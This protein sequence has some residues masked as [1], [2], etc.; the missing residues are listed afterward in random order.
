MGG[1]AL[2][3]PERAWMARADWPRLT[4][5]GITTTVRFSASFFRWA[6]LRTTGKTAYRFAPLYKTKQRP[7]GSW[8]QA[9]GL[10]LPN[11]W[12]RPDID[13]GWRKALAESYDKL[14]RK[15]AS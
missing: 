14:H 8:R 2:T 10:H 6:W 1:R 12:K 4:W 3:L 7:D 9:N 11:Y 13:P 5:R 15:N